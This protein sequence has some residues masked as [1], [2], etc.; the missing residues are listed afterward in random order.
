MLSRDT[1]L[2]TLCH[3]FKR[4][5]KMCNTKLRITDK[6]FTVELLL[7][8]FDISGIIKHRLQYNGYKDF[9]YQHIE[10]IRVKWALYVRLFPR[11]LG[12]QKINSN[13]IF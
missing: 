4:V 13:H 6:T 12:K 10:Q 5:T 3:L 9:S 7:L 1:K 2:Q 8:T 11:M